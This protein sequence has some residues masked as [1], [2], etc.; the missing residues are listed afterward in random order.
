MQPRRPLSQVSSTRMRT[1]RGGG[2]S[3][4]TSLT[5]AGRAPIKSTNS[6]ADRGRPDATAPDFAKRQSDGRGRKRYRGEAQTRSSSRVTAGM[7]RKMLIPGLFI[8][9]DALMAV[10]G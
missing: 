5:F 7:C 8:R 6:G 4:C 3:T 10:K 9:R 2:F 1:G